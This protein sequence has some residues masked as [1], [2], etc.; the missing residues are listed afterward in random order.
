MNFDLTKNILKC[1]FEVM[2]E[3]GSRFLESVY[4]NALFIAMK[5]R[6]IQVSTEKAFEVVLRQQ[7]IERYIADL[8][9]EDSIIIELK[10]C[11][12]LIPEHQVQ[13]TNYLAVSNIPTGLLINFGNTNNCVIQ[14]FLSTKAMTSRFR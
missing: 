1:C 11:N 14:R 5:Q 4:K 3:L 9:N 7:K 10:C 6:G 13:L 8:I 12:Y 2:K